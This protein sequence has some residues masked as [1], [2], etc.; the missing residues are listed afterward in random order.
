MLVT[1]PSKFEVTGPP[2]TLG[3]PYN[4]DM[5]VLFDRVVEKYTGIE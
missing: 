1:I 5:S 3:V 4:N 2:K